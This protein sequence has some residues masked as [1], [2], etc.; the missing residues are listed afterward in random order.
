MSIKSVK[1]HCFDE[2]LLFE[3]RERIIMKRIYRFLTV[4]LLLL[5]LG[6]GIFLR[7]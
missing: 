7:I 3:H 2:V 4:G 5:V 1:L 6:G